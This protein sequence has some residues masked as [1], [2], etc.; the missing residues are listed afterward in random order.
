MQHNPD[1]IMPRDII[2]EQFFNLFWQ[3]PVDRSSRM[4]A[5]GVCRPAAQFLVTKSASTSWHGLRQI[6]I[7]HLRSDAI[8]APLTCGGLV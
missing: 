1:I 3:Q 7:S 4:N 8:R 2:T 5:Q 6:F